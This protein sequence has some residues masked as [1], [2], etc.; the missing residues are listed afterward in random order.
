[1]SS[2]DAEQDGGQEEETSWSRVFECSHRQDID[3]YVHDKI[4]SIV[5]V[6]LRMVLMKL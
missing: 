5:L 2:K 4:L 3:A 1:M 6:H